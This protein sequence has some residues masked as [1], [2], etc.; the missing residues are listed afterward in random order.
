VQFGDRGFVDEQQRHLDLG[1]DAFGL[2]HEARQA[3][4]AR[5]VD[6]DGALFVRAEDKRLFVTHAG[7]HRLLALGRG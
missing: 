2:Q 5:H 6:V 1:D 7:S 3:D 4:V